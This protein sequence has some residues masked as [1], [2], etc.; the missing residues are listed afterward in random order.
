MSLRARPALPLKWLLA[1]TALVLLVHLLLLQ[2]RP[3]AL[4]LSPAPP[5][6]TFIMRTIE[7][8]PLLAPVVV[9]P[10]AP[11]QPALARP[12]KRPVMTPITP[13]PEV[14]K[15]AP[16]FAHAQEA[17]AMPPEADEAQ[18]NALPA[19]PELAAATTPSR[20]PREQTMAASSFTVPGSVRLKYKVDTNKLP[21]SA[22]ADLLWQQTGQTYEARLT[23]NLFGQTRLQSSSGRVT[24]A[25]LAPIRFSDKYRSE[26]AAHFNREQGKVTFS[27]NTPDVPL[28]AGAQ[29]RLS[30]LVQLAAMIAGDPVHFQPATTVT[31]QTIGPRDA[32]TW[33]FTVGLEEALTLPGGELSA[34]K[35]VRHPRREFDQKVELWLAPALGYLP[36]RIRIT[37]PNG[38]YIDQQ[39]RATEPPP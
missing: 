22:S 14:T 1:L 33:L 3:L 31:L 13:A 20:P 36:A 6:Q 25:G 39:W 38:D 30:I 9:A 7:P 32:D 15:V 16:P 2:G 27:A 21:F 26:V 34:L 35:L 17:P 12:K 10:V 29:D 11:S 4:G 5:Q 8:A 24:P 19:E 28:L 23:F 37:E 18:P